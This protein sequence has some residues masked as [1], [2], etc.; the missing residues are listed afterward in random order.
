LSQGGSGQKC[1]GDRRR[2]TAQ[3]CPSRGPDH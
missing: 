1:D 2:P 3:E